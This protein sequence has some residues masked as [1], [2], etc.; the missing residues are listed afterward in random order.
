M[1]PTKVTSE[2]P[3]MS[4]SSVS[5][6]QEAWTKESTLCLSSQSKSAMR[7]PGL[8]PMRMSAINV[9][10]HSI[11]SNTPWRMAPRDR[12]NAVAPLASRRLKGWQRSQNCTWVWTLIRKRDEHLRQSLLS[13]HWVPSL[14]M[15]P[16]REQSRKK[17][18]ESPRWWYMA[19]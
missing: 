19:V 12:M 14:R 1:Q 15:R 8:F 9:G 4:E 10:S 17:V 3:G 2:T 16:H 18:R 6:R 11:S 13:I 5:S 7:A